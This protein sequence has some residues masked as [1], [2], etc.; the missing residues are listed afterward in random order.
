MLQWVMVVK[1]K[2][3]VQICLN[4]NVSSMSSFYSVASTSVGYRYLV[5]LYI[6]VTSCFKLLLCHCFLHIG[7]HCR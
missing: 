4:V 6:D 7:N 1:S 5:L 3:S 2:V